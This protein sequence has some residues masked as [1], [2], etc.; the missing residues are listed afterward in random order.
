MGHVRLRCADLSGVDLR[1]VDLNYADVSYANLR[2]ADLSGAILIGA[3][4]GHAILEGV[5]LNE[6]N[7]EHTNLCHVNLGSADLSGVDLSGANL[8]DVNLSSAKG[9]IMQT[10]YIKANFEHTNE[11]I[12]VYK[13]FDCWYESPH[14]WTIQ[15]GSIITENVNFNRSEI[16][17]SGI[18]VATLE[19]IR[20]KNIDCSH[21]VWKCLIR[22]EWL[23]GVC[24]PYDT[25]GE[26]RCEK[27]EIICKM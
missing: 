12:I 13:I 6:A 2:H 25:E 21:D 17:G 24:V 4:F 23:S 1:G 16:Y 26:I 7:L 20:S 14:Y 22:Y 9:L 18:N 3:Y 5:Q 15:K 8:Q 11:G 27:L 19:Y 10:D